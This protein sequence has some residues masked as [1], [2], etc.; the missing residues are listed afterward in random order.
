MTSS[1]EDLNGDT[2]SE[3]E[4]SA[5]EQTTE[6]IPDSQ[7][8]ELEPKFPLLSGVLRI[9]IL[10]YGIFQAT[11]SENQFNNLFFADI[12]N[13]NLFLTDEIYFNT[14]L[15]FLPVT[16]DFES[17]FHGEY[18]QEETEQ[19]LVKIQVPTYVVAGW[20]MEDNE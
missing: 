13:A 2:K 17:K 3:K 4:N 19:L 7:P 1:S 18:T 6:D 12:L 10:N 9:Q 5:P 15:R 14:A 16:E 20:Y 11:R 8:V